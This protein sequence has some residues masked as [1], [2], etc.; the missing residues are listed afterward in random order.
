ML[1]RDLLSSSTPET[2]KTTD[3][4]TPS[5][6]SVFIQSIQDDDSYIFL[7]AVQGLIV[8]ANRVG[9]RMVK[10][11]MGNYVAGLGGLSMST[12]SEQDV[13]MRTRIGEALSAVI[14]G[15]GTVL[16]K[17]GSLIFRAWFVYKD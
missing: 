9:E 8:L 16:G 10:T 6:L 12:M 1:L 7:N 15:S 5:I 14:K 2:S 3:A 11:L 13:D 4:L 17:Y